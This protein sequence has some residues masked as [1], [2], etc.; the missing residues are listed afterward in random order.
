MK[1]FVLHSH[2]SAV[3]REDLTGAL[4]MC[5]HTP[6]T[7][8]AEIWI[9]TL[10]METCRLQWSGMEKKYIYKFCRTGQALVR[11]FCV[12]VH[13]VVRDG[14]FRGGLHLHSRS[15]RQHPQVLKEALPKVSQT[16]HIQHWYEKKRTTII[17]WY[18]DRIYRNIKY[19]WRMSPSAVK[20]TQTLLQSW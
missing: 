13:T 19:I 12:F 7:T 18:S 20:T 10:L 15:V 17:M 1:R 2:W 16:H 4:C 5:S 14:I 9:L 6:K 11:I 8:L 3:N